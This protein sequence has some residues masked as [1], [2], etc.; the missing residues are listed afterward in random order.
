MAFSHWFRIGSVDTSFA[1]FP[2]RWLPART[3]VQYHQRFGLSPQNV[4][5]RL[6]RNMHSTKQKKT[7]YSTIDFQVAHF[8][9]TFWTRKQRHCWRV[10]MRQMCWLCPELEDKLRNLQLISTVSCKVH[11]LRYRSWKTSLSTTRIC[12]SHSILV[13]HLELSC[14]PSWQ[15]AGIPKLSPWKQVFSPPVVFLLWKFLEL[16]APWAMWAVFPQATIETLADWSRGP[17]WVRC[18][19]AAMKLFSRSTGAPCLSMSFHVMTCHL[20]LKN[21]DFIVL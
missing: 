15:C 12:N 4:E 10:R 2:G 11:P 20:V 16:L 1:G 14:L 3:D 21:D 5:R 6:P 13:Q 7:M 9:S 18:D 19:L 8:R 17:P